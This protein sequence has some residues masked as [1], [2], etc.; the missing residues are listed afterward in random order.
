MLRRH[1]EQDGVR[2]GIGRFLRQLR[3]LDQGFHLLVYV[4]HPFGT[5]RFGVKLDG[6]GRVH[7][8]NI[9]QSPPGLLITG[10]HVIFGRTG[11]ADSDA[12]PV[13]YLTADLVCNLPG[14]AQLAE[15]EASQV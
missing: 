10:A 9:P 12:K 7:Q 2:R 4:R 3:F 6:Q 13:R 1:N 11:K 5:G 14:L 15:G 8:G